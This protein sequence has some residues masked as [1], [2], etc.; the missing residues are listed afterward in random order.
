MRQR[1]GVLLLSGLIILL[2]SGCGSTSVGTESGKIAAPS[3]APVTSTPTTPPQASGTSDNVTGTDDSVVSTVSS[4]GSVSVTVGASQTFNVVFTSSDGKAVSGFAVSGSLGSLPSGW[5]SPGTFACAAVGPGS[6]CVLTLTYAPTMV[7]SGTLTFNCVFVDNAKTARTPGPCMTLNYVSTAANNVVAAAS[8]AGEVDAVVGGGA[9]ALDVNFT[10]DDGNPA[11]ALNVTTNLS[12]LPAGWS[13]SA[14]SLSCAIVRVGNGCQLPLSFA[15]SAAAGATL[16]LNYTYLDNSGATRSGAVTIPYA[17]VTVGTVVGTVSPSGQINAIEPTGSGSVAVTF[18]S[19][20][21]KSATNLV[22]LTDLATLPSDWTGPSTAFSCATVS[23]GNGC[24]LH[25]TYKPTALTSGTFTLRYAYEGVGGVANTGLVDVSYAATT[26]DNVIYTPSVVGETD[27]IIGGASQSVVFTFD[28][29]DARVATNLQLMGLASLPA[30]WSSSSGGSFACAIILPGS[31]CQLTLT[32]TPTAVASGT[33]SLGY[34]YLNNA[35]E[36][37][38]GTVTAQYRATANDNLVAVVN[39][40]PVA[41]TLATSNPVT[42]TFTM[43]DGNPGTALAADL[44]ALP[45]DWSTASSAFACSTVSVGNACT[46]TLTYAPTVIAN[47]SLSFVVN[48]TNNAGI[49]K[50]LTVS[51]PY[52]ATA[53][54]NLVAVVNPTPVAATVST[55]NPVTVTFTTDDGNVG[56]ALAA[57]LS[58]LPADWSTAT[59][60]FACSTFSVGS[61]CTLMLTYAPTVIANSSLSFVVNYTNNAGINKA[62][63]VSIPY[64][65][66]P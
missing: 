2:M 8:L 23:T 39:P 38:S 12:S 24:Q 7:D 58:A 18:N 61:S 41:A 15:P 28:T 26:D 35:G 49:N 11:T 33:L 1:Q 42:V 5:S 43:D 50:A 36:T 64:S 54:D 29:D 34:T 22:L 27:V 10:T 19:I 16:T 55:S 59:S 48:Y 63:T 30:G 53:N 37:K 32:Y 40:T 57:D 20:D 45:A 56:T 51:I 4:G 13:S 62:M 6:G 21:G 17:S 60:S 31:G 65:A 47:S 25:L 66:T 3:N 14:S 52:Q 44:S 9:Q 46:L